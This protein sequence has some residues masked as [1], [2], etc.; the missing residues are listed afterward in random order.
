MDVVTKDDSKGPNEPNSKKDFLSKYSLS[1]IRLLKSSDYLKNLL[2]ELEDKNKLSLLITAVNMV[3]R[4]GERKALFSALMEYARELPRSTSIEIFDSTE[5]ICE[6]LVPGDLLLELEQTLNVGKAEERGFLY[7]EKKNRYF[8][9]ANVFARHF[10]KRSHVRSTKGGR[11]FLYNQKGVYEEL[12]EVNLGNIIRQ[13]MHEGISN[14]WK[15][16]YE[17][18]IFKVLQREAQMVDE[19]DSKR[20]F[21]NVKNGM[22]DLSTYKL[23]EHSPD[24]NSTVQIPIYY[25]IEAIAPKFERFMSDITLNDEELVAVHQELIGY[26]LT[27]ETKAEKAVYY[28]GS[29]ANGKSVLAS[30]VTQLVGSQNVSNVPLSDFNVPFGLENIIGK[31]LNISA[32]NEMGGKALKTE[33]FKAIVSGDKM[34]INIKYRSPISY[35]PYCRLVFLVNNLP[36]S[37]DVTAGYFRKVMIVPFSRTFKNKEQNV[38]LKEELLKELPGIFTWALIGLKRLRNNNYR[39]SPCKAIEETER[40]YMDEQNPVRDFFHSHVSLEEGARTKQSDFYNIYTKWLQVQGIDDK[41]TK[42]RQVF[43]RYFKVILDNEDIPIVKKKVKGT[44]YF[45]GMKVRDIEVY[46]PNSLNGIFT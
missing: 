3:A 24:F 17:T 13:V 12:S 11:L 35:R 37:S 31:S 27:G 30:V 40:T 4:E 44:I 29:G 45:D 41:G 36:D 7:D 39:F 34:N 46:K 1:N 19:M 2:Q 21:I 16:T 5:P 26:W 25:D 20:N 18:E 28:Y 33:N 8:F 15:S 22:V 42:S 23:V 38:Y 9:N 32:E 6:S 43:W 10:L 14:S